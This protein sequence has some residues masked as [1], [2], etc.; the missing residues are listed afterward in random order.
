[1][2]WFWI[3]RFTEFVSGERAVAIKNVSLG[4]E[5]LHGYF[6]GYP[7]M[8]PSLVLEGMAQTGGMLVGESTRYEAR[9]VLA[10]V[11]NVRYHATPRPGDTLTYTACMQ[12][13]VNQNGAMLST[14]SHIGDTLQAEAELFLA[15]LP[16][17]HEADELF[18]PDAFARLLRLLGVYDVGVDS[19][20]SPI[21]MPA[22]LLAAE[23]EAAQGAGSV[24]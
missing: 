7:I 2:R 5:H 22:R 3:D 19:A 4:E 6:D 12:S 17:R 24:K 8:P 15:I 23:R 9:L 16:D 20:G 13:P 14:T 1:M 18:Q 21:E 11:S 10:K